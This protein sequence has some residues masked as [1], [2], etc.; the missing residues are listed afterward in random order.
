LSLLRA[1]EIVCTGLPRVEHIIAYAASAAIAMAG[2]GA[3]LGVAQTIGGFWV[4]AGI[5]NT[6]SISRPG[7]TRRSGISRRRRSGRCAAVL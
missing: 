7:G 2:Y 5:W 1:Q 3:S 4:Y 6:S